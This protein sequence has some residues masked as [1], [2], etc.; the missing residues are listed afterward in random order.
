MS[1]VKVVGVS[2]VSGFV[3]EKDGINIPRLM[4]D[5]KGKSKLSDLGG[6]QQNNPSFHSPY[7]IRDKDEIFE[8]DSDVFIPA[9]MGG[10]INEKT[11]QNY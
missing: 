7:N 9:A 10:V 5:M 11:L 4:M 2:D 6:N 3:Y 8:V 1:R